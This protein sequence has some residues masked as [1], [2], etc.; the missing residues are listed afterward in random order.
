MKF[1]QFV[2][3]GK[4]LIGPLRW[5]KITLWK[6]SHAGWNYNDL[7]VIISNALKL[8][9]LLRESMWEGESYHWNRVLTKLLFAR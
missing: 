2:L 9:S 6:I 1:A 8:E 3:G 7:I 5:L 4:Y